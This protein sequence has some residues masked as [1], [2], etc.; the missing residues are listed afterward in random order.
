MQVTVI[1]GGYVGLTT[2]ACLADLGIEVICIEKLE[3]KVTSLNQGVIPIFEPGLEEIVKRNLAN[4]R[5]KFTT[6]FES[7]NSSDAIF[8][9]VGT[10]ESNAG[11]GST[12]L[13]QIDGAV[14]EIARHLTKNNFIIVK[15]TVP[16]GTCRNIAKILQEKTSVTCE[17]ISNPEFLREGNAIKDFMEPER[18]VAGVKSDNA[19]HLI[20]QIYG[21]LNTNLVF[22]SL[23]S[24]ELIK[25]TANAFLALKVGFINEIADICE[26]TG[27]NITDVAKGIGL[28]SRIGDKFLSP[29]PGFGGSC[30][31]KDIN[32]LAEIARRNH[33]PSDVIEAVIKSNNERKKE[34]AGK[35]E[36]ICNG[37]KDKKLAILGLTFKA[38][39]DDM[40]ES[41]SLVI[42]PDLINKG[43]IINAYDPEGMDNAKRL[44]NF[45]INWCNSLNEAVKETDAVVVLT[46]WQEFKKVDLNNLKSLV[47]TPLVIDFRKIYNRQEMVKLGFKYYSVG[48]RWQA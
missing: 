16:V 1:G 22:T 44:L 18:I 4:T 21:K 8:L 14:N 27:A 32:A 25:Q 5:L 9:A 2:S 17:V 23:E 15:S 35:I 42:V 19:K 43:A 7:I 39:T 29:G 46:E 37:I 20:N 48:E 36:N 38:N 11:D 47:K 28:D 12:D 34:I 40:R 13:S 3:E 31:P 45:D 30:F 33:S 10:P 41:P 26:E 24:S 6:D